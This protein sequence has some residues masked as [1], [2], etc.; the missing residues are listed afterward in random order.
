MRA[1]YLLP[2]GQQQRCPQEHTLVLW[3]C[4]F[5][6]HPLKAGQSK[7]NQQQLHPLNHWFWILLTTRAPGV[8]ERIAPPLKRGTRALNLAL[9]WSLSQGLFTLSSDNQ[10]F[11]RQYHP[12][13]NALPLMFA[14]TNGMRSGRWTCLN[15]PSRN[16]VPTSPRGES[17]GAVVV[18]FKPTRTHWVPHLT[19]CGDVEPNPGPEQTNSPT[20]QNPI[21]AA[22]IRTNEKRMDAW[23]KY[24]EIRDKVTDKKL[25]SDYAHDKA[26][27]I[28]KDVHADFS[29]QTATYP[30]P[31]I[32]KLKDH[33]TE[34]DKQVPQVH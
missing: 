21:M 17:L 2:H 23:K 6:K 11:P 22:L 18:M 3:L 19:L 31:L 32:E 20:E 28:V 7:E 15:P 14:L 13:G 30:H 8:E 34:M 26:L 24:T 4:L 12:V 9:T 16:P 1:Q 29:K 25:P 33:I 10:G 5:M 27:T